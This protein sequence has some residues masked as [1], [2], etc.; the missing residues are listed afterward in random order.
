MSNFFQKFKIYL[1]AHFWFQENNLAKVTEINMFDLQYLYYFSEQ[2][3]CTCNEDYTP[4]CGV[5]EETYANECTAGCSGVAVQCAGS[6]P[7]TG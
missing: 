2:T 5:D 7:C 1:V 4:V 3:F 6:C